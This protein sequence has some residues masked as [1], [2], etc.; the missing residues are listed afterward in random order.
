MKFELTKGK[1]EVKNIRVSSLSACSN[2][3]FQAEIFNSQK[4]IRKALII[5]NSVMKGIC[6]G[7]S[8]LWT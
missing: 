1:W 2:Y 3:F 4:K 6:L 7:N 5:V 8:Y